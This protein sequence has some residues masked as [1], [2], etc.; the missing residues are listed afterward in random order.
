MPITS[1]EILCY[2]QAPEGACFELKE[3]KGGLHFEKLVEYVVA[4]ANSGGG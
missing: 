1:H 3:A 4:L 2:L